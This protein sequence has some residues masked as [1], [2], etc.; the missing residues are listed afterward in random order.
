M[1]QWE[2]LNFTE[3]QELDRVGAY[4]NV[5]AALLPR[6]FRYPLIGG[7]LGPRAGLD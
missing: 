3:T 6:K 7:W 4:P 1:V 2:K 5:P